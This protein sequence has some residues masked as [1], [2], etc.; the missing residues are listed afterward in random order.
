MAKPMPPKPMPPKPMSAKPMPQPMPMK[1]SLKPAMPQPEGKARCCGG[2]GVSVEKIQ[3]VLLIG[4]IFTFAVIVIF[5]QRTLDNLTARI[6]KSI[7]SNDYAIGAIEK[8]MLENATPA[9]GTATSAPS[10]MPSA[11]APQNVGV[12]GTRMTVAVP[13]D[14]T[15]KTGQDAASMRPGAVVFASSGSLLQ[16][17]VKTAAISGDDLQAWLKRN[18]S[19]YEPAGKATVGP[20]Q[21]LV[22]GKLAVD[23]TFAAPGGTLTRLVFVRDGG[24]VTILDME[25]TSGQQSSLF[26]SIV[27]SVTFAQ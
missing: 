13:G 19:S 12:P 18:A 16:M 3:W 15:V 7:E 9:G 20:N 22:G 27:G 2:S 10:G 25:D 11:A 1:P 4:A 5:Q 17:T 24:T 26:D 14:W 6:N 21:V 8:R 23:E